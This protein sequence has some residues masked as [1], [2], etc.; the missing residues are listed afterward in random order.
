MSK[1][2]VDQIQS[3]GGDV[4]TVPTTDATLANQPIVGS[5][6]GVLTFSPLA[7]P[8]ADGDANKPVTTDGSA[9]LQFGAFALPTTAGTD[10]Q[11]LT[12]TGTAA[13]WEALPESQPGLPTESSDNFIGTMVT[14]SS[15]NNSYSSGGWNSSG[16]NST[17]QN[18]NAFSSHAEETWNMLLGDGTP[19]STTGA[20]KTFV[21]NGGYDLYRYFEFAYGVRVGYYLKDIQ[22][23]SNSTSYSGTTFRVLPIRNTSNAS[24]NVGVKA[25]GSTYGDSYNSTAMG[26][27]TPTFS[28]G[29]NYA[30][31]TG[32]G[33]T[34]LA[35]STGNNTSYTYPSQTVTVP[36][37]VTVLVVLISGHGYQTTSRFSDTNQFIDLDTTF[38]SSSVIC[39]IRMLNA[40]S[41]ARAGVGTNTAASTSTA[42]PYRVYQLCAALYGD[43]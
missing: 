9:H 19:D 34:A 23:Y 30:N 14:T 35:S 18:Q 39:D 20:A 10:G 22:Y 33:W 6:S 31:A 16:P 5:T 28:S 11:V 26:Y 2:I 37:G 24:I 29:T 12:S 32:G 15:R 38:T 8:S 17:Y 36:A 13:A 3:N 4:L 27:Y 7:L 40:L 1:I 42:Y 41:V 25:M 21:N 43:R